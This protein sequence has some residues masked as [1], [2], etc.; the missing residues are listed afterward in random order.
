M[1]CINRDK[2]RTLKGQGHENEKDK[3]RTMERKNNEM[4][5]KGGL[6][7][8]DHGLDKDLKWTRSRK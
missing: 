6:E 7:R 5:G 2:R 8:K 1:E 4:T 3:E